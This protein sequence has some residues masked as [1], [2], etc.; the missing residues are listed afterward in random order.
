MIE[1]IQVQVPSELAQ[2]LRRH[3]DELPQILE[4]G[5]RHVESKT[6]SDALTPATEPKETPQR[7]DVLAALRSTGIVVDLDPAL[8][9][10]YRTDADQRRHIPIQ[11]VDRQLPAI[12]LVAADDDLLEAAQAEGLQTQNPNLHP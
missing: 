9:V 6:E 12:T 2:R 5:L 10:E 3:Y 1:T 8:A 11:L 7:E 4:W